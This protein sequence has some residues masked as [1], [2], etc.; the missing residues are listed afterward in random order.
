MTIKELIIQEYRDDF[1]YSPPR[2][3]GE[4]ADQVKVEV[5][6]FKEVL[7]TISTETILKE[8]PNRDYVPNM[9][10]CFIYEVAQELVAE[11]AGWEKITNFVYKL[12]ETE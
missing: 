8:T 3:T 12:E 2:F 7:D 6:E 10:F 4:E 11:K 1:I 5:D 9:R